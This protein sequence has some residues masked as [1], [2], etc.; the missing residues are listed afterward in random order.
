MPS[1]SPSLYLL[2]IYQ[3]TGSVPGRAVVGVGFNHNIRL[4]NAR[5]GNGATGS[6]L[7]VFLRGVRLSGQSPAPAA[8]RLHAMV[9]R[10]RRDHDT[11]VAL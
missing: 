2:R 5:A 11:A 8:G 3:I 1:T 4:R 7:S 6:Q 9:C 10:R